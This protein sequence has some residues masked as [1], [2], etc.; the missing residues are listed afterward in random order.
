MFFGTEGIYSFPTKM[1]S[2][3][4]VSMDSLNM[5]KK[6]QFLILT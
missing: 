1:E 6:F 2:D 4:H 5:I 3:D